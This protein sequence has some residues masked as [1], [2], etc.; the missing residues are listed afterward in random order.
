[1]VSVRTPSSRDCSSTFSIILSASG[2]A[3]SL[4][5]PTWP[6]GLRNLGRRGR[7]CLDRLEVGWQRD[8]DELEIVGMGDFGVA[9]A[10]RLMHAAS[11]S[12]CHLAD[13]LIVEAHPLL[14]HVVH[15]KV[16]IM[17]VPGE[18]AMSARFRT[19]DM[20]HDLAAGGSGDAEVAVLEARAQPAILEDGIAGVGRGEF[21]RT[22]AHRRL[23]LDIVF[24]VV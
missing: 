14:E 10:R 18:A 3:R 6:G 22:L 15:L 13:A 17:L 8:L 11:R 23:L 1:M 16:E 24:R 21:H 4:A 7:F 2:Q 5:V 12:R 9:D 20:L 19:D